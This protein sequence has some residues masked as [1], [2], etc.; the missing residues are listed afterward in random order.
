M[1]GRLLILD[2]ALIVLLI[3]GGM[4]LKQDWLAFGPAH[5][6]AA[7]QPKPQ[8]FPSLPQAGVGGVAASGDWTEIPSKDPFSFDRNDID[9]VIAE[10]AP[11]PVGPKPFLSGVIG[12]GSDWTALVSP[13]GNRNSKP[14]KLGETIDGWTIVDITRNSIE[15]ESNGLRQTVITNDPSA[16]VPREVTRTSVS[17]PNPA[18]QPVTTQPTPPQGQRGGG[19]YELTPFGSSRWVA[20][21]PTKP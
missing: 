16:L 20:D 10:A 17:P 13:A 15:I 8:A 18:P 12:I 6:I 19:H 5:D 11:K 9:I 4:K 7:V 14:M 3:L 1:S 2:A 21:P